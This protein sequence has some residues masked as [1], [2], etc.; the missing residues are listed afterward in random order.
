MM[1]KYFIFGFCAPDG[2]WDPVH[3]LYRCPSW[4]ACERNNGRLLNMQKSQRTFL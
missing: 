2:Y 3:P 1:D 4:A